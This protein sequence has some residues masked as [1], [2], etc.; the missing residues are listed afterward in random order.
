MFS[1]SKCSSELDG[2]GIMPLTIFSMDEMRVEIHS[3]ESKLDDP[4]DGMLAGQ[5]GW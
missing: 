3:L 1:A 5:D 2:K 4:N